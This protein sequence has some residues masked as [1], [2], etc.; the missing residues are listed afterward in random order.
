MSNYLPPLPAQTPALLC[1]AHRGEER[2]QRL[3]Y[4]S[5]YPLA[6]AVAL[7]YA[8][9]ADS[10]EDIVQEAFIKL[11]RDL[12]VREFRG[13]FT[14]YLRRIVV[15]TGIDHYRAGRRRLR[16]FD[17]LRSAPPPVQYNAGE[18]LLGEHDV[19][20][21]LQ[22]LTPAYRLVFNLYVI[23]GYLHEEIAAKLG[24]SVGT[25]KSNLSKAKRRLRQLAGPY[26]Q[27]ETDTHHG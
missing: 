27:L 23:E 21:L 11:F 18:Q 13:D 2:A 10:A 26:F 24:I 19:Y 25:S 1:A 9:D 20:R 3:L 6:R 4:E 17:R 12:L 22:Q 7:Q 15:N 14:A 16:L 8:D 5:H